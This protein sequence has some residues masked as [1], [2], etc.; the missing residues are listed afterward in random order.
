MKSLCHDH[1]H[2]GCEPE[3]GAD[4]SA[5]ARGAPGEHAQKEYSQHAAV[6]HRSDGKGE[7]EHAL[8]HPL[9]QKSNDDQDHTPHQRQA[10]RDPHVV[11]LAGVGAYKWSVEIHHRA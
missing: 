10:S 6:R 11:P 2:Q 8:V 3:N 9:S 7:F 1:R 5:T 4:Q